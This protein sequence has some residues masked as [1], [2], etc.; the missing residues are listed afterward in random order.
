MTT[1]T[2]R[3]SPHP[4]DR[5]LPRA[6]TGLRALVHRLVMRVRCR[7]ARRVRLVGGLI[8]RSPGRR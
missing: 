2:L 5:R 7:R 8:R 3:Q 4:R 1:W 6:A